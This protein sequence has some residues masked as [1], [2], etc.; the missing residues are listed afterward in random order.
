MKDVF[1]A[2]TSA[3]ERTDVHGVYR[4]LKDKDHLSPDEFKRLV[5]AADANVREKS[6]LKRTILEKVMLYLGG[7]IAILYTLNVIAYS[8]SSYLKEKMFEAHGLTPQQI[9][10]IALLLISVFGLMGFLG[11]YAPQR[12][13]KQAGDIKK[14][15]LDAAHREF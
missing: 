2:L 4:L 1:E 10:P 3:L 15:L 12:R 11:W 6:H 7:T 13:L 8:F 14:A 9:I 5:D